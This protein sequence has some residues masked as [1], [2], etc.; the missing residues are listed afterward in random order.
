MAPY[1]NSR[2]EAAQRCF[3]PYTSCINGRDVADQLYS[4]LAVTARLLFMLSTLDFVGRD[5]DCWCCK[6][7]AIAVGGSLS[8][9]VLVILALSDRCRDC[10]NIQ[11]LEFKGYLASG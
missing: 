11:D 6:V 2:I 4:D 9:P 7:T 5:W 1:Y 8:E 3:K 10:D